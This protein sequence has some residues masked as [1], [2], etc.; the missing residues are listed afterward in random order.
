MQSIGYNDQANIIVLKGFA[1][2]VGS[3]YYNNQLSYN[4][5]D[6]IKQHLIKRGVS[7][8]NILIL[9]HGA[10]PTLNAKEARR[11]EVTVEQVF[12]SYQQP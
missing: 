5:S 11:V 7:P 10:D 2:Q 9:H 4:R 1:S 6:V 3:A 8:A 12:P